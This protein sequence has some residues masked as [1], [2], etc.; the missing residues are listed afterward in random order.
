MSC[1]VETVDKGIRIGK[2]GPAVV[3]EVWLVGIFALHTG[4]HQVSG[5]RNRRGVSSNSAAAM[6]HINIGR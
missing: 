2:G 5:R 6:M 1:A 4:T 3:V